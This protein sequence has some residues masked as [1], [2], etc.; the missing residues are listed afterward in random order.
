MNR[1]Y[2]GAIIISPFILFLFLGG[3]Y[4]FFLTLLL[5]ILGMFEFYKSI[6]QKNIN[7]LSYF[8]FIMCIIYY[9]LI[10]KIGLL[11]SSITISR[12]FSLIYFTIMFLFFILLCI[13]IFI[14]KYNFIDVFAT[15][16]AFMYIGI[17]F[18]FIPLVLIS[19]LVII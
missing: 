5:S 12:S 14:N 10:Y 19:T 9:A 2:L 6:K 4:L 8:G 11:N 7:A 15:V 16:F 18:S 17:F 13:P 3:A 1:R